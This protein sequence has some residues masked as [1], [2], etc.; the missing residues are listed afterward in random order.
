VLI[1]GGDL[2]SYLESLKE[3]GDVRVVDFEKVK[4]EPK[5][6]ASSAYVKLYRTS[7]AGSS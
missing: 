4:A 2:K 1:K 5:P 6:A 3:G 7:R